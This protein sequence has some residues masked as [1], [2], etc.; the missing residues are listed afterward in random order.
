[1]IRT[2]MRRPI[3]ATAGAA[4]A[5][6]L[7]TA[8]PVSAHN[9]DD[10]TTPPA[11]GG[12]ASKSQVVEG[13]LHDLPVGPL[14]VAAWPTGPTHAV[15]AGSQHILDFGI[16]EANADGDQEAGWLTADSS[17]ASIN[18]GIEGLL[19]IKLGAITSQC[20]TDA[21]GQTGSA[22]IA[23]GSIS[24]LGYG[25]IKIPL[26]PAPNTHL[27]IPGILDIYLNKQVRHPDGSLTVTALDIHGSALLQTVLLTMHPLYLTVAQSTCDQ[28]VA[29]LAVPAAS[30][31]GL[32][33]G[34]TLIALGGGALLVARRRRSVNA[35]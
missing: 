33:G 16:L 34:A 5:L 6:I 4:F 10:H 15:L 22:S 27:S 25:A 17:V 11:P 35:A 20:R 9:G 24:V 21:S 8:G 19:A 31:V 13:N 28:F 18:G 14:T 29:P 12:S 30:G 2:N 3:L 23:G 32:V 7:A 26:D 1:M